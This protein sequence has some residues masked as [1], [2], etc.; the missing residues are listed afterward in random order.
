MNEVLLVVGD[1]FFV[2][3]D[4]VRGVTVR[5]CS[6]PNVQRVRR[7]PS[8]D[9]LTTVTM[10]TE[11]GALIDDGFGLAS[12]AFFTQ[13]NNNVARV[14]LLI[15][16][17]PP[18]PLHTDEGNNYTYS[19]Y[20]Y[21]YYSLHHAERLDHG[22]AHGLGSLVPD[23]RRRSNR[24]FLQVGERTRTHLCQQGCHF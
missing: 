10:R 21:Y 8:T 5:T 13:R 22:Y 17:D 1:K 2:G 11:G 18:L 9:A 7:V 12:T 6:H 19:N 24:D 4:R 23:S 3:K 15:D 14:G 20:Y 16:P